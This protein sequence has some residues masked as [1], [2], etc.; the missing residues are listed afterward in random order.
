MI[1]N[2]LL[3]HGIESATI[4]VAIVDDAAIRSINRRHLNHDWPTDVISFLI[5]ESDEERM[6][7][8][9]IVSAEMAAATAWMIGVDPKDELALY[10]VHGLLHLCGFD[11]L[12]ETDELEMRAEETSAL[13]L[14]G[15]RNPFDLVERT[16]RESTS[17]AV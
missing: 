5:S 13:A 4:S 1:V 9:L 6:Q 15:I 14:I 3:S 8:E 10:L 17:W 16:L 7:G 12:S 11:D 2:T